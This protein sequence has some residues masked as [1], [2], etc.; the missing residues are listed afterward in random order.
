MTAAIVKPVE[1]VATQQGDIYDAATSSVSAHAQSPEFSLAVT[2]S[3]DVNGVLIP[4]VSRHIALDTYL[5]A[6]SDFMDFVDNSLPDGCRLELTITSPLRP[7]TLRHNMDPAGASTRLPVILLDGQSPGDTLPIDSVLKSVVLD[8]SGGFLIERDRR[9]Y[10]SGSPIGSSDA[11]FGSFAILDAS[12]K[13]IAQNLPYTLSIDD[14]ILSRQLLTIGSGS[15][16]VPDPNAPGSRWRPGM[17]VLW[18]CGNGILFFKD[19]AGNP[20]FNAFGHDSAVGPGAEGWLKVSINPD[21]GQLRWVVTGATKSSIT[22][23]VGG[24]PTRVAWWKPAADLALATNTLAWQTVNSYNHAYA[25]GEKWL[26][27]GHMGMQG[28]GSTAANATLARMVRNQGSDV[29]VGHWGRPRWAQSLERSGFVTAITYPGSAGNATYRLDVAQGATTYAL[30]AYTPW[31]GGIR[32]ETDE[33]YGYLAG[34]RNDTSSTVWTDGASLSLASGFPGGSVLVIACLEIGGGPNTMVDLQMVVDGTASVPYTLGTDAPGASSWLVLMPLTLAAGA[35]TIKQQFRRNAGN[36][37]TQVSVAN[38]VVA[39]LAGSRF[40]L[41]KTDVSAAPQSTAASGYTDKVSD[42]WTLQAGWYHMVLG[43]M[44]LTVPQA[45]A[46]ILA[47]TRLRRNG[48]SL[49][50][51]GGFG[52]R[53]NAPTGPSSFFGAAVVTPQ[54]LTDSFDIGFSSVD[55]ADTVSAEQAVIAA[56]ALASAT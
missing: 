21:T 34:P 41:F 23:V 38:G 12:I 35:H 19:W 4:S 50:N 16:V 43:G 10:P 52:S 15:L 55:N 30:T 5:G 54:N 46:G 8:R 42:P 25:A 31:L 1:K 48:A 56:L 28:S 11:S 37:S 33:D 17:Q 51:T 29:E 53:V 18:E 26:I 44:L 32:L 2:I 36:A 13:I 47:G 20:V 6:S 9:G 22:V 14:G 39:M 40:Q 3:V 49:I 7:V 27:F 24:T 45:G